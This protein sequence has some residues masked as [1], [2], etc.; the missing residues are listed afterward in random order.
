MKLPPIYLHLVQFSDPNIESFFF[1]SGSIKYWGNLNY[2]SLVHCLFYSLCVQL[3]EELIRNRG[4]IKIM[5]MFYYVVFFSC[6]IAMAVN[7]A[8]VNNNFVIETP[9]LNSG[10]ELVSSI[11]N[12]CLDAETMPCLKGKVLTYL[13]TQLNIDENNE[14]SFA[15]SDIDEKIYSRVS[16]LLNTKEFRVQ[17]PETFFD[18]AA[19]TFRSDRGIDID[20]PNEV[21]EEG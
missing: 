7:G 13:D 21:V 10:D 9:R 14:R 8:S 11:V 4:T 12:E 20:L 15:K 1:G 18:N 3:I 16:R 5:T 2:L 6:A 19:L 17:L